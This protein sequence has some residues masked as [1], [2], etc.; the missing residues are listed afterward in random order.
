MRNNRLLSTI[1][2]LRFRSVRVG[3][4]WAAV[5]MAAMLLV[6]C[7]PFPAL[8]QTGAILSGVV[9]DESG[10]AVRDAKVTI[11]ST[12]T[13]RARAFLTDGEG[14]YTAPDLS[15]GKYEVRA[16]RD[17]FN[18]TVR[19][20]IQ[21]NVGQTATLEI[22]LKVGSIKEQVEV[23]GDVTQV[24]T[25]SS[26]DKGIV[27]REMISELPL[28]G[29]DFS[30]LAEI[31]VGV[32]ANPNMG[33][34][35]T[36]AQGAGP[37]ISI[38]GSR[39]NQNGF[40][41]DGSDIQD[42]QQRTPSG[43]SGATL[44]VD[45]VREFSVLT[46]L[47]DAEYG[48]RS[49]G[50]INA[51][52]KSGANEFHGS[53]FEYLRNADLDARNFFDVHKPAFKRNQF[54]F[55]LGGPIRHDKTFFFVSYEG[56]RDRLGSTSIVNTLTATGRTGNLGSQTVKVNPA[57]V[58]YLALYPLPNGT[59]FGD[60]VGQY[61]STVNTPTSEDYVVAKVDHNISD[62][63]SLWGRYVFDNSNTL[64]QNA[65]QGFNNL[66]LTR[67]Q[68][69]TV[70]E[71]KIL[72]PQLLNDFESSFNRNAAGS[73]AQQTIDLPAS[74]SFVPGQLFGS[75]NVSGLGNYGSARLSNRKLT[76]NTFEERDVLS[77]IKGRHVFKA[78]ADFERIQFNT[79]SAF[80]QMAEWDFTSVA[81]FLADTPSAL[82][83][84]N[85]ASDP[86]RGWRLNTFSAFA[87]DDWKV[88]SRLTLNLGLRYE[89][90]TEPSEVN[91]KDASLLHPLTDT[92]V[93][94]VSHLY[95]NPSRLNFAPRIG[96]GWDVFGDGKTALRGG[97]GVYYDLILPVDWIFAAT[98]MPPFFVRPNPSNPKGFPSVPAALAASGVAP[99]F[100][101]VTNTPAQPYVYK[102]SLNLQRQLFRDF[103]VTVGYDGNH[104]VHMP[105]E[106]MINIYQFQVL[107]NGEKYFPATSV[108]LNPNFG[109]ISY[110][111][112]D[113]NSTYN[114][115][116]VSALKRFS[117]RYQVQ[118]NYT[119]ANAMNASDGNI[120]TSEVGGGTTG[121]LDPFDWKRDWARA[122]YDVRNKATALSSYELPRWQG[123]R[124]ALFGSW[125]M[126]G[127]LTL[128]D[129]VPV[130]IGISVDVSRSGILAPSGGELRPNLAPGGSGNPLVNSRNPNG[131]WSGSSFQLP[132]AGYLGNLG[133]NT[134]TSP[135]LETL[136]FSMNKTVHLRE[137]LA[138][139]LRS[140]AF[141]ILNRANFGLPSSTA[142][143]STSGVPS[144]SFGH[145]TGT[146]TTS[147]Q[148]QFAL[149]LLF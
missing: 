7:L 67:R 5:R 83:V 41:L 25:T 93:S 84:M 22:V 31:Q 78:G 126:N 106:Q 59:D 98:N 86:I 147:R 117:K 20:G 114:A 87:Q 64:S 125:Q 26:T 142:F 76:Q 33:K 74:L 146:A 92:Q 14:R 143:S 71:R 127:I 104:G 24:E 6:S 120:G 139:Q 108:R 111:V 18:A 36:A 49:G 101:A 90:A 60:G 51:I 56:L 103:V 77:Y 65:F 3:G 28:N 89:L 58:P 140:E 149:K 91:G 44:G 99:F 11:V 129:G 100:N 118:F 75:L 43:V 80:A 95:Q 79:F 96:F 40:L 47:F 124:G 144:G 62:S 29:R 32:Y 105:R 122:A 131:Y 72:S 69:F 61:I 34:A 21:L 38:S 97:T 55:T 66:G 8:A 16:E 57:V 1:D 9:K 109:P 141:N 52:T 23:K 81:G 133:R 10:A 119:Y 68:F 138:L 39:P 94:V 46:N 112:F 19:S 35:V 48:K 148:V 137:R 63:D 85:P 145:I 27:N 130:N 30:Q 73:L 110:T 128:E 121:S 50:I 115:L 132:Q 4:K 134:G 88:S 136:D 116:Q 107:A 15:A 45:T 135:G 2:S 113:T 13:G 12:D 54:G 17:G 102:Y 123:L 53:T 70:G 82:D 42:A 37:R